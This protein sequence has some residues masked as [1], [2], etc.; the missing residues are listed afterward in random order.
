MPGRSG[1]AASERRPLLPNGPPPPYHHVVN[2]PEANGRY[3]PIFKP[4]TANFFASNRRSLFLAI[5][6]LTIA[7][8]FA[9]F[10]WTEMQKHNQCAS[11]PDA[12]ERARIVLEWQKERDAFA[13]E[14]HGWEDKRMA[15][16]EDERHHQ[17]E[18][19]EW[20]SERTRREGAL[21]QWERQERFDFEVEK[22]RARRAFEAEKHGWD[23]SRKG[24]T[25]ERERWARERAREMGGMW[26]APQGEECRA[27]NLRQYSVRLDAHA[28]C[29][30]A[31]ITVN[32]HIMM[33]ETCE[34]QNVRHTS[35]P[36]PL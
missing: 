16:R 17:K 24:W 34:V 32:D 22:G 9:R 15:W 11:I 29:K 8:I 6:T 7:A 4:V 21:R 25:E 26:D 28:V 30:I 33:A 12:A 10:L 14:S 2:P 3:T 31:P 1:N 23:E 36:R 19:A 5:G 27:Y 18:L 20:Q 13:F 35:L